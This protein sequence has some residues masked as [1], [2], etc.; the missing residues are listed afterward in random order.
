[1]PEQ[2]P[3]WAEFTALER[4][5]AALE[6]V[7]P[8]EPPEPPQPPGP[9]PPLGYPTLLRDFDFSSKPDGVTL[10][11]GR[12]AN[13]QGTD[14]PAQVSFG[15]GPDKTSML[16]HAQKVGNTIYTGDVLGTGYRIPPIYHAIV[17][18]EVVDFGPGMW[19]AAWTRPSGRGEGEQDWF[20]LFGTRYAPGSTPA[21]GRMTLHATPYPSKHIAVDLAGDG[22]SF[23][24]GVQVCEFRMELDRAT[25][26]MNGVKSASI[27]QRQFD[28]VA[29]TGKWAAQMLAHDWYPRWTYQVGGQYAGTVPPGWTESKFFIH[30]TRIYV[31]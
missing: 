23:N 6:T 19:P 3:T 31:P 2:M 24:D 7:E 30:S 17:E 5:V 29:G 20:E 27:T 25:A 14:R 10:E 16:I 4:R 18:F 11:S 1:M 26:W 12:P 22:P 28:A 8:P 13:A 9:V 15:Q 21:P